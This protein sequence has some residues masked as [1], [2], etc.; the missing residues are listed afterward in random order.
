[1]CFVYNSTNCAR[2]VPDAGALE[3]ASDGAAA[4]SC[5]CGVETMVVAAA[6]AVKFRVLLALV[7]GA[8]VGSVA[9][10]PDRPNATETVG[11]FDAEL[12]A[13]PLSETGSVN[14]ARPGV[15]AGA[16]GSVVLVVLMSGDFAV[17][18]FTSCIRDA[19]G[20]ALD[21]PNPLTL[22]LA[23]TDGE[24]SKLTP[25][26]DVGLRVEA[27]FSRLN[28]AEGAACSGCDSRLNVFDVPNKNAGSVRGVEG[29][30]EGIPDS[31]KPEEKPAPVLEG[32][33]VE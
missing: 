19:V 2:T 16:V 23:D 24:E 3:E 27:R 20:G 32:G 22:R 8:E 11:A 14:G 26:L 29:S 9:A 28:A 30:L 5:C 1:M 15:F 25:D 7:D 12:L 18:F 4:L 31:D 33:A 6:P 13:L 10:M 17:L 21:T